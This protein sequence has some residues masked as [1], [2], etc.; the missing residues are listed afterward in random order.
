[1]PRKNRFREATE[2]D[3]FLAEMEAEMEEVY[4]QFEE[5]GD[6]EISEILLELLSAARKVKWENVTQEMNF[7][8]SS[9][10]G[11]RLL[12]HLG[13]TSKPIK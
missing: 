7:T 2:N 8:H 4:K 13:E 10:K 11:W 5:Q 6:D 3:T 9:K 12:R 1:M